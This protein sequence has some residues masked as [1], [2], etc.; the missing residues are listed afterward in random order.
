[1]HC[2]KEVYY[3]EYEVAISKSP[4]SYKMMRT[5]IHPAHLHYLFDR[6]IAEDA[7]LAPP[8]PTCQ[9]RVLW[10]LEGLRLCKMCCSLWFRL[11]RHLFRGVCGCARA[12]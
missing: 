6:S 7:T 8:I 5:F 2:N 12:R 11:S 3:S 4:A 10:K 1:V 9:I